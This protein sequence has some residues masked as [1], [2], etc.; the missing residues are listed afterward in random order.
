MFGGRYVGGTV[1]K[2]Y[3]ADKVPW[4]LR[5]NL[6]RTMLYSV[7]SQNFSI[8]TDV[9]MDG[10]KGGR[11]HELTFTIQTSV[12]IWVFLVQQIVINFVS[13]KIE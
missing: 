2:V 8:R 10:R 7:K 9:R 1:I 13:D 4:I 12:K 5:T 11:G 6:T 3:E